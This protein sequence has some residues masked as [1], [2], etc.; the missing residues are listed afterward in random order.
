MYV[1]N[2]ELA[3]HGILTADLGMGPYRNA[4]II[5][6]ILGEKHF[7]LETRIAFQD[8]CIPEEFKNRTNK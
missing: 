1:L 8:F 7:D 5:N 4:T 3:S 6:H 2:S